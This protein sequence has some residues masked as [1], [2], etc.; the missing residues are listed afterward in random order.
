MDLQKFKT[1]SEAPRPAKYLVWQDWGEWQAFL[2]FAAA[3]FRSRGVT[4]P[5]VVEIGVMH[6]E[7][8]N[9]YRELLGAEHIGID[10][11][12]NNAPDIVGDSAAPETVEKLKVLL[13]G[14][15]IDLLF[16]DGN[17]SEYGV[18]TDYNLYGP[19]TRHL[20][21]FHDIHGVT[22]RA[23]GVNGP[24]NEIVKAQ[25]YMTAIFHRYGTT[26]S[27]EEN[28]FFNMGIGVVIKG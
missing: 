19:L 20:I 22:N 12:V 28:R 6:N 23:D 1:L 21:A 24:W 18:R 25:G 26:F 13:V 27:L 17:H 2:E 5:L 7:Q 14:R 15:E 3:Y 8:R 4:R 16:I 9:F 11:N 10:I